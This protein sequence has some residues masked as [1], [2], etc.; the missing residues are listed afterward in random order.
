M[1]WSYGSDGLIRERSK[2][3]VQSLI[4][5]PGSQGVTLPLSGSVMKHKS[6]WLLQPRVRGRCL[7]TSG[8]SL[9]NANYMSNSYGGGAPRL[10]VGAT[11]R[12]RLAKCLLIHE[13][14]QSRTRTL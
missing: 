8:S 5:G 10:Q 9:Y 12:C 14:R 7:Y 11:S 1:L 13:R 2:V 3:L 6:L 4:L